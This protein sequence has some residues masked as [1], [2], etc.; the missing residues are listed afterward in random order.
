V[1]ILQEEA[2]RQWH[3]ALSRHLSLQSP[4][5][6]LPRVLITVSGG[7]VDWVADE[8][9]DVEKFDFDDYRDDPENTS[10]PSAHFADLAQL[11]G[12]PAE[13]TEPALVEAP[14]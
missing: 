6:A 11:A 13:E 8:G 2:A 4:T 12:V 9:I 3:E 14:Q 7:V 10:K 1:W 5:P